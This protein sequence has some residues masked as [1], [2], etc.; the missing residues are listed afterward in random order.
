MIIGNILKYDMFLPNP[1]ISSLIYMLNFQMVISTHMMLLKRKKGRK[2]IKK[3][4]GRNSE[5]K[6]RRRRRE[7]GKEE[8]L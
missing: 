4:K 6:E 3:K 1:F 2:E 7:G 8:V 5:G